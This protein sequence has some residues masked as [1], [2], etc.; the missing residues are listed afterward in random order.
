M[1]SAQDMGASVPDPALV[2]DQAASRLAPAGFDPSRE[3]GADVKKTLEPEDVFWFMDWSRRKDDGSRQYPDKPEKELIFEP[4]AALA[5]L[6]MNEVI[7]LN[8]HWWEDDWP[9]QARKATSL[10][11]NCNDVF[12]WGCSDAEGISYH[13]LEELYHLWLQFPVWGAEL[14][15]VMK[16]GQMPQKP[17]ADRMRQVGIDLDERMAQRLLRANHYDGV[18]SVL[19]RRKYAAYCEWERGRGKEPRPYD[20]KWW[21]GWRE[22][23]AAHP[24]WCNDEWRAADDAARTAWRIENGY[25]SPAI[26]IEAGTAE[27]EGL[28]PQGESAGR[29]ASPVTSRLSDTEGR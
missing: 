14:W 10:N 15:C 9:E 19:A 5:I 11:V 12:A 4:E 22:Y 1:D 24:N 2:S 23:T 29:E 3:W 6:L 27:T 18:S 7:S 17:V 20:S 25:E 28:S 21:D 26:A 16:R 13:E 8:T